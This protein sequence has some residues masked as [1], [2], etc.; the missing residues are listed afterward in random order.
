MSIANVEKKALM[1]TLPGDDVRQIMWRFSD[2][3]EHQ[4]VVQATRSVAR[5]IVSAIT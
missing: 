4:M 3:Y 1:S 5:G 2:R